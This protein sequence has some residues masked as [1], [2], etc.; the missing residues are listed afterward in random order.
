MERYNL[1]NNV[2]VTYFDQ[3]NQISED[4]ERKDY[5]FDIVNNC[6]K[7]DISCSIADH[8]IMIYDAT[9]LLLKSKLEG[10]TNS[11]NG[12][13][14]SKSRPNILYSSSSDNSIKIWDI[15]SQSA[16]SNKIVLKDE[17]MSVSVS[18]NDTLLCGANGTSISFFDLRNMT[19]LGDYDDV[20]S[21]LVT[22]VKFHPLKE[23][24][25]SSASEDNLICTFDTSIAE[26]EDAVVSIMNTDCPIRRMG[27]F[28]EGLEGIFALST[29]ESASFWHYPSAQRIANL[30]SLREETSI[31]YL[32]DG[33]YD[34]DS[35][36][37]QLLGGTYDG[38]GVIIN[39][40]PNNFSVTG[41]LQQGHV[42]TLRCCLSISNGTNRNIITGGEDGKVCIW[43]KHNESQSFQVNESALRI[44]NK[45]N[46]QPRD[47]KSK[48]KNSKN[49]RN[50]L[51]KPY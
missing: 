6:D 48:H 35:D 5:V 14:Y 2:F 7:S 43:N 24:I 1:C 16:A 40:E 44:S 20:H 46:H 30:L 45:D 33:V 36:T 10:H 27:Y 8:S 11:I 34:S 17:A 22:A 4:D 21:D 51:Y 12:I 47:L 32:V 49:E 41:L 39:V 37:L 28:G 13:E 9:N 23:H 3:S 18:I 38:K 19:K 26:Q 50:L 25:V 15:R 31:D 42:A 29:T